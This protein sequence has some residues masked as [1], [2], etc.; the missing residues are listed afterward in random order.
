MRITSQL[1]LP[2]RIK[3]NKLRLDLPIAQRLTLGFLIAALIAGLLAGSTALIRIQSLHQQSDFYQQLLQTKTTLATG[4]DLLE[5]MN[6]QMHEILTL[7]NDPIS[8]ETLQDDE[9]QLRN[10]INRYN[11]LLKNYATNDLLK[12]NPDQVSLLSEAHQ[13]TLVTTQ[14]ALASS[15]L[16]TWGFFSKAQLQILSSI[17]SNND[18]LRNITSSI[19]MEHLQGEPTFS[20][21]Q[22]AMVALIRFN[23]TLSQSARDAVTVEESNQFL[24]TI[25]SIIFA[26]VSIALVGLFISNT[27]VH[28]LK[29]LHQVTK[30]VEQGEVK[31]RLHVIGRDEI[32]DISASVNAML[33]IIASEQA[34]VTASELKDQFIASV[35]HELRNP[36]TN[37]FGWLEILTAYREQLDEETQTRFLNRAMEGCQELMQIVNSVLDAT[38]VGRGMS[39]TQLETVRLNPIIQSVLDNMDP[40]ITQQY[41]IKTVMPEEFFV[42]ADTQYIR[43]ILRNLLTNACKYSPKDS[44]ITLSIAHTHH[45][46]ANNSSSEND[47]LYIC[48]KDTGPGIPAEEIP[49]LF[50]S[51]YACNAIKVSVVQGW[52]STYASNL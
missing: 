6:T 31:D 33:E 5:L 16:R 37:V 23:D 35:S 29:Q 21:A 2:F 47:H 17:K 28:R 49:H 1:K 14:E 8:V 19:N 15:A 51:L 44:T 9:N 7:A 4:N 27:V 42:L 48:V 25:I 38:Q 3:K 12:H 39:S 22:S 50:K 52:A 24:T 20:D 32:A 10:L 11:V 34:I 18:N 43:Q 26:I 30:A 36:L 13:D 40:R 41:Y 45:P 46:E